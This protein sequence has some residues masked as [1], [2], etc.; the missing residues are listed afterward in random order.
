MGAP[1]PWC[2]PGSTLAITA[3]WR[4]KQPVGDLPASPSHCVTLAFKHIKKNEV[5]SNILSGICLHLLIL[6]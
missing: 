1:D 5:S 2:W 6:I 4:G 3:V